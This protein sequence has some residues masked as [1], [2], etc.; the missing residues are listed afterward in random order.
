M[1]AF[2]DTYLQSTDDVGVHLMLEFQAGDSSAL[3]S[4]IELYSPVV[5]AIVV[6]LTGGDQFVADVTQDV[7][8][9]VFNA[10]DRYQPSAKFSSWI[11]R[12][13][14]NLVFNL[15]RNLRKR[16]T[17]SLEICE[18]GAGDCPSDSTAFGRRRQWTAHEAVVY[19]ETFSAIKNSMQRLGGR[20][21][22]AVEL[23]YFESMSYAEAADEM[24]TSSK[25]IKALLSRARK[26]LREQLR[27]SLDTESSRGKTIGYQISEYR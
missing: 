13:T 14:R 17:H 9:R 12:I 26:Q 18:S 15:L 6:E 24:K 11:G 23:V 27:R 10:R 20:Q 5:A 22:T 16:R 8:L 7:F 4:L 2:N 21:Q 25:A 3:E 19:D 1:I